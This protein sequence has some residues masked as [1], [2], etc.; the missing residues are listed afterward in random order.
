MLMTDAIALVRRNAS[1]AGDDL[2]FPDATITDCI[3]AT[4]DNL[5]TN[6]RLNPQPITFH[7]ATGTNTI[8]PDDFPNGFR[9]NR[10]LPDAYVTA[11]FVRDPRVEVISFQDLLKKMIPIA[12]P[13][14][15]PPA[16]QPI[17][18][19]CD[20]N[21]SGQVW[22]ATDQDYT[23]AAQ[24]VAPF[25][26]GGDDSDTILIPDDITREALMR[27]ASALLSQSHPE[28]RFATPAWAAYL[29]WAQSLRGENSRVGTS[30]E[31][32][33]R[34]GEDRRYGGCRVPQW[35]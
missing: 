27:G 25:V 30:I 24:W 12:Y 4:L 33:G 19:A 3:T 21:A 28:K 22:P 1:N 9:L 23:V 2:E 13:P 31:I 14:T 17:W 18:L 6:A 7:I 8:D 29:A 26:L 10:L 20:T 15:N 32:G 35:L 34:E 11:N 16:G 5:I